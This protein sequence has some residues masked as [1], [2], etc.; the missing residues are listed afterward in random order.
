MFAHNNRF[1]YA[2]PVTETNPGLANLIALTD[3]PGVKEALGLLMTREIA[4]RKPFEK[5][6][7]AIEPNFPPR[8]K[9]AS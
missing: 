7:Y 1:Q 5:A 3:D 2:V 6:L 9:P 4:H 8:K